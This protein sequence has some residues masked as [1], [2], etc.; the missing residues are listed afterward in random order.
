MALSLAKFRQRLR[1]L[2]TW[3]EFGP[4]NLVGQISQIAALRA[5]YPHSISLVHQ[6]SFRDDPRLWQYN[7]HAYAF[8]LIKFEAFW[9]L[10]TG[11]AWADGRFVETVLLPMM[12]E[13]HEA[14]RKENDVIVYF[15]DHGRVAHSGRVCGP[16][17][18]SKWGGSGHVWDHATFE[19]PSSCG[20]QVRCFTPPSTEAAIAAFIAAS[21]SMPAKKK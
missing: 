13:K 9:Q 15:Y 19:V 6:I 3:D 14:E 11:D 2:T 16:L 8:G 1:D 12:E 7:C 10:I 5:E 4:D 17:V 21:R 18:R 20:S